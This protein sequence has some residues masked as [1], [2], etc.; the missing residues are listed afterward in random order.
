M[1]KTR[2]QTA[3]CPER[4]TEVHKDPLESPAGTPDI[5]GQ[6]TASTPKKCRKHI[7]NIYVARGPTGSNL[8]GRD[9]AAEMGLVKKSCNVWRNRA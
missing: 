2:E 4:K 5:M 9:T 3:L 6:F 8:L 1:E 7:L